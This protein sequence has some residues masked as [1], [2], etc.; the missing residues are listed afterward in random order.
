MQ[1]CSMVGLGQIDSHGVCEVTVD[2]LQ[3]AKALTQ[4]ADAPLPFAGLLC[5]FQRCT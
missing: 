2:L 1:L 4:L 3:Q 5:P